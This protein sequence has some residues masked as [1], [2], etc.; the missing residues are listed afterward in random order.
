[1]QREYAKNKAKQEAARKR[2]Q[3][4]LENNIQKAEQLE[5]KKKKDV[6]RKAVYRIQKQE[7]QKT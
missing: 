4:M 6:Y 1:M 7:E 5:K 2:E 3:E